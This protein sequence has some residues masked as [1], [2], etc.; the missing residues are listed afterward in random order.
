MTALSKVIGIAFLIV[1]FTAVCSAQTDPHN[2]PKPPSAELK[3]FEPLLGKYNLTSDFAGHKWS[4]TMEIKPA[5]R[6]W[7]VERILVIKSAEGVD[8]EFRL[9]ITYDQT[10]KRYRIWRFETTPPLMKNEGVGRFDGDVFV[11]EYELDT[12]DGSKSILRNRT[13]TNNNEVRTITE[14]VDASGKVTPI[15]IT[16]AKRVK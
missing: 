4:G 8:R 1:A 14:V 6:G 3:K 5:V 13:T 10:L 15:G 11:E 9:M 7:Y 12:P 2:V 16:I